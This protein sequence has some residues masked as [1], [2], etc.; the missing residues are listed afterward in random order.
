MENK[1]ISMLDVL[2]QTHIGLERQG[3]GSTAM[4]V[5][6]LSFI[7]NLNADSQIL[8][9]GCGTGGQT[10]ILA[11]NTTG[12][13]I[14]IDQFPDF[15][16]VL[17]ENAQKLNLRERVSGIVGDIKSMDNLSLP[18]GEI[19]V[20]WCEGVL[21]RN[22]FEDALTHWNSFL[23]KGGYGGKPCLAG[24]SPCQSSIFWQ[25]YLSS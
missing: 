1:E 12:K 18:K 17:C 21:D 16:S 13:I 19:D 15:V 8:D 7:D 14:G 24:V 10:I 25:N 9:L 23:K 3:P 20:V 2:V 4:T 6:A 22:G 11:Q 5:K